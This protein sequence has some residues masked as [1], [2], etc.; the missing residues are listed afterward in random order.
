MSTRHGW[1]DRSVAIAVALAAIAVGANAASTRE[2]YGL[3]ALWT[4]DAA[5]VKGG[6]VA[7][8][9]GENPGAVVGK[10]DAIAGFR[11][12]AL[13][14]DGLAD[15]VK[16]TD[17]IFFP[18]VTMEAI[19]RPTLGSRNPIYDKYNYGI[20]LSDSNQVGI[21]IRDDK[22]QWPQIYTPWPTDGAWHHVVGV[23]ED[24]A[25][26]RIYLDGKLS[27]TAPAPNSIDIAYGAGQKPTV[28]YTQ[29]LGGIW[30]EGDVDEVAIYEGALTGKDVGVLYGLSLGV[31]PAGKAALTW[32]TLKR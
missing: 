30:Y 25:E 14:F 2:Q 1:L 3:V 21:W 27:G 24:G 11:G 31:E 18:S 4:F 9:F 16:M 12:E 13:S 29:H 19:I 26:V 10:P 7:P 23:A 17:D 15:Y 5:T 22:E 6:A 32:A 20:Q 28:A 8:E